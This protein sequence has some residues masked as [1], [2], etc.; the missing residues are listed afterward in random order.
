MS[1]TARFES[2]C[3]ACG[4]S[5]EL[6][7]HV[8]HCSC[9]GVLELESPSAFTSDMI[10]ASEPGLWRYA[11]ALPP[12][13]KEQRLH[14]GEVVTPLVAS[15]LYGVS[16]Y[17]KLDYLLPTGSYKDR[18]ASVLMSVL[19]K[20]GIK[21]VVDDS[22]GN[23]GAA[24]AAYAAA[25]GIE[26]TILVPANNS[27]S[28]LAQI[29][30]YGANLVAIEGSR[31]AVADATQARADTAFYASHVWH[32]LY[33]AGV[34]TLGFEIWEQLGYRLPSAVVVPAG[35]GSLVLG[36][37]R[38]FEALSKGRSTDSA[39]AILAAQ[40]QAF[41]PLV[42]SFEGATTTQPVSTTD[43]GTI[44]E[45]IA[46]VKPLREAAV[47]AALRAGGGGAIAVSESEIEH[48]VLTLARSGFYVE[49]TAAV[50][51]AGLKRAKLDR[52]VRPI[53]IV[54]T[55]S[56]LKASDRISD[57]IQK[58]GMPVRTQP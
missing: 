10:D 2:H 42:E 19:R 40:T 21:R 11:A 12:L 27:P 44:A 17:L 32:P 29:S 38:A 35:Q 55:G 9:G 25:A 43:L 47:L 54:L 46:C 50:A 57:L 24:A 3:L 36:L 34:A 5:F 22:S 7:E 49:P 16:V 6:D 31:Q 13:G 48:A 37:A 58:V 23:A 51:A 45:G 30:A 26:C 4:R 28:K 20:N 53:V 39:P 41:R 8:W 18:G 14:L 15:E 1:R 33:P 56:G 52:G